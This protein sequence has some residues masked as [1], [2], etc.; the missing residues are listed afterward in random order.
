[1]SEYTR[2][3][4]YYTK[5]Q[6]S[7]GLYTTGSEW[8][9]IDG[10]EYIGQYHKYTTN[11]TFTHSNFV[12][13]K[14]RQL[15]PYIATISIEDSLEQFG[16]IPLD[17]S[18]NFIYDNLKQV[19]FKKSAT[20]NDSITSPTDKD[21]RRGYME[22][23]FASKV[24]DNMVIELSKDAYDKRGDD[25]GLDLV[26]WTVF[27]VR[28]KVSGPK[29]DIIDKKRGIRKESG[30]IDTN[31]RTVTTLAEKYPSILDI[32]SNFEEFSGDDS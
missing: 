10:E 29:Y 18:K 26:L 30:I 11:E 14:S 3:R 9:Y 20:P 22:R 16:G 21:F 4:I 31:L 7:T 32:L 17:T 12:K 24:N 5:A 19:D 28:W 13:D 8:M 1:M 25:G 15:V 2:K 27:K 6:I 23:I